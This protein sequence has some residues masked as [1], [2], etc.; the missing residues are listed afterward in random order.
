MAYVQ[1]LFEASG[2]S[3]ADAQEALIAAGVSAALLEYPLARVT[4]EQFAALYRALVRRLAR[5]IRGFDGV[6]TG[7]IHL[8][9]LRSSLVG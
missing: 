4:E 8:A 9:T 7:A 2:A 5:R 6:R 1:A 3:R